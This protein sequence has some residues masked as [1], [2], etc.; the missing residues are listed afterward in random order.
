MLDG[1]LDLLPVDGARDLG[2]FEDVAGDVAFAKA[3]CDGGLDVGGEAGRECVA[4]PE[5][6]E[7]HDG[8]VVVGGPSLTDADAVFDGV[9][10]VLV[11]NGVDLRG[12]EADAA[13]VEDA[14]GAA[15][16]DDGF[17]GGVG[18]DEVAV[19]PDVVEAGEIG[20][21]VFLMVVVAPKADGHV[22]E[23]LGGIR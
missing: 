2:R 12:A 6:E 9:R 13:R 7:E 11:D 20:G 17:G 16:E 15:E 21:E 10:K 5:E 19:G 3:L 23:G 14:V 22:W 8:L 4:G 1:Q 18:E